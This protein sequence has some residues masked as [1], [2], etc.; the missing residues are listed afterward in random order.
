MIDKR[1]EKLAYI[2]VKHSLGI[3]KND[4]FV[5]SGSYVTTP[6]IK[7][8]YKQ[9]LKLGANPYTRV[10]VEGLAEVFYKNASDSQ[11]K[12]VSPIGKFE[13]EKIDFI[14]ADVQGAEEDLIKG[15]L[16]SLNNITKYFYTEFSNEELYKG[17]PN[18]SKILKLL[19]NFKIVKRYGNNVLLKNKS[20]IVAMEE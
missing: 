4:L 2:L 3:K 17:Q 1:L 19:P 9:A 15:G 18:L 11:L 6:L 7:E 13:I 16:K 8:V 5:I 10:G 14:W 12:F 20:S